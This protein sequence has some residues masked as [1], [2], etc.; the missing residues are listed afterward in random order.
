MLSI[1]HILYLSIASCF[2]FTPNYVR[3]NNDVITNYVVLQSGITLK[4]QLI[5]ENTIYEVRYAFDQRGEALKVPKGTILKFTGGV[6]KNCPS[7]SNLRDIDAPLYQIFDNVRYVSSISILYPEWFGAVGDGIHDD[8]ES[9]QNAVSAQVNYNAVYFKRGTYKTTAPIVLPNEMKYSKIYGDVSSKILVKHSGNCFEFNTT[10]I[11][12][13]H[14]VFENLSI[15]GPNKEYGPFS[16]NLSNGA[17]ILLNKA[18]NNLIENCVI[19]GFRY[20]LR[21]TTGIGNDAIRT[22]FRFCEY[23]IYLDGAATNLNRFIACNIRENRREGVHIEGMASSP[24]LQNEFTNCYIENN[25]PFVDSD[26]GNDVG[27]AFNLQRADFTL[28]SGCYLECQNTF[29]NF[30]QYCTSSRIIDCRFAVPKRKTGHYVF[31]YN[32]PGKTIRGNRIIRCSMQSNVALD[33]FSVGF[34]SFSE[35]DDY[36]L[37]QYE[38]CSGL[39]ISELVR[40]SK[41]APRFVNSTANVAFGGS[42]HNMQNLGSVFQN[43]GFEK[44]GTYPYIE[45]RKDGNTLHINGF[46]HIVIGSLIKTDIIIDQIE[47]LNIGDIVTIESFG[48]LGT[49]VF[50]HKCYTLWL[51]NDSDAVFP[52]GK[53]A[54]TI[55][56]YRDYQGQL[57]ELSRNF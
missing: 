29:F 30:G 39:V 25:I 42:Y 40:T 19:L 32:A 35:S 56:F 12:A 7:I 4:N 55:T 28:I 22:T 33:F 11:E 24:A 45:K 16:S 23:G 38:D 21:I 48:L 36:S 10:D 8:T 9:I 37:D 52:K 3:G 47:G 57:V 13:G 49:V 31:R 34:A 50:K 14:I 43:P 1:K 44:S 26:N 6:I 51:K 20:G 53:D 46:G 2:I 15:I 41:H 27:I 54:Y 18:Y 17:G 5:N